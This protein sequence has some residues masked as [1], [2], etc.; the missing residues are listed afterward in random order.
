MPPSFA[1]RGIGQQQKWR[2]HDVF[3]VSPL[4]EYRRDG[5]PILAE[6]LH[7]G[8]LLASSLGSTL[9]HAVALGTTRGN[10]HAL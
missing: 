2:L 4:A 3:H 7:Q 8:L 5:Q 6:L 10:Q 1:R 9:S